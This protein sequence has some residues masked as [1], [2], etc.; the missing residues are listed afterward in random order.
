M[1]SFLETVCDCQQKGR[2]EG[3][4]LTDKLDFARSHMGTFG[5]ATDTAGLLKVFSYIL[6]VQRNILGS[7]KRRD[8]SRETSGGGWGVEHFK[9]SEDI[10]LFGDRNDQ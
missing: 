8:E 9:T 5:G 1:Q 6:N 10:C 3:P 4:V 7:G 2:M